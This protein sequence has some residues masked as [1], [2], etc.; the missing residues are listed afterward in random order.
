MVCGQLPHQRF[1]H[2]SVPGGVAVNAVGAEDDLTA[3]PR[4]DARPRDTRLR[5]GVRTNNSMIGTIAEMIGTVG[6]M[7]ATIRA[8]VEL[9]GENRLTARVKA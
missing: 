5:Q 2:D 1:G 7:I 8:M 6:E 9:A 3:T 4:H